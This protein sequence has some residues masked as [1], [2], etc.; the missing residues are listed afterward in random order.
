MV[1]NVA[2]FLALFG[3]STFAS[4]I[5]D[6]NDFPDIFTTPVCTVLEYKDL[7]QSEPYPGPPVMATSGRC[8]SNSHE[9]EITKGVTFESTVEQS[10]SA[11]VGGA[12][13]LGRIFNIGVGME[14][15]YR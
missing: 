14:W 1:S 2:I 15:G 6:D 12:L 9:C 7:K 5:P 11:S 10:I 8:T 13:D 3:V 4:P